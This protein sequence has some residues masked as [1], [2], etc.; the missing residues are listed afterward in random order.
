MELY[1]HEVKISFPG[2]DHL[3]SRNKISR[4]LQGCFEDD[5]RRLLQ[6]CSKVAQRM[7]WR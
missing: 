5:F 3:S 2:K 4:Q 7:L 6:G 1:K